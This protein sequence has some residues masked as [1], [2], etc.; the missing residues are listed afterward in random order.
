MITYS[1]FYKY[2]A[3][4]D[5]KTMIFWDKIAGLYDIAQKSFNGKVY[6]KLVSTTETLVPKGAVVLDVA[7][8]TGQLTFAAAK[9]A[10]RVVCTDLS[11]KMLEVAQRKAKKNSVN[12]VEFDVR[13]IFDLKDNDETYDV[14]MA[15]NVLHLLDNPQKAVDELWR[16]TKKGGKLL[17]PTFMNC[18][19][20]FPVRIYMKMGFRPM[21]NYSSESYLK[22]LADC[23][24]GR[25]RA[26]NIKGMIPSCY[27][28]IEKPS[29]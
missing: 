17:L 12:N 16:V 29:T 9:N 13:D 23:K 14:V 7:A 18:N 5:G 21:E 3:E 22:M 2:N 26:K 4:K 20:S 24:K 6:R 10:E 19:K 11:M 1:L 28:V 25:V 27:A 15:G 8:G